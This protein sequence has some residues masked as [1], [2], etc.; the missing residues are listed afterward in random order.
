MPRLYLKEYARALAGRD[1]FIACREGILRDHVQ[2]IITDIK[3]LVRHGAR[4]HLLHNMANR[5]A[6]QKL[7]DRLS[8]R[9]PAT[10]MV[11]I[12]PGSDFYDEV[13]NYRKNHVQGDLSRAPLSHRPAGP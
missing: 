3:F 13:L 1:V 9:L 4:T 2:D 11:R 12:F 7:I 5:F 6:N 10:G 8:R